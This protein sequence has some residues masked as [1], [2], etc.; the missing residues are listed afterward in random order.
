VRT[1]VKRIAWAD[2]GVRLIPLLQ[3]AKRN[4]RLRKCRQADN[5]VSRE[6]V[7]KR[8]IAP[9]KSLRLRTRWTAESS[10]SDCRAALHVN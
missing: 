7:T 6:A 1:N 8:G 2:G 10:A 5:C 4:W 9:V 3:A